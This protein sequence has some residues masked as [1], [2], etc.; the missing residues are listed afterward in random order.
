M[1][2]LSY[3]PFNT[4]SI[5]IA[6]SQCSKSPTRSKFLVSSLI[7]GSPSIHTFQVSKSGFI[8]STALRHIRTRLTL[9]YVKSI[10]CSLAC[11]QLDYANSILLQ[12][13]HSSH[14]DTRCHTSAG[15]YQHL[16]TLRQLHEHHVKWRIN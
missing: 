9:D 10:V 11:Y 3:I 7:A 13:S 8:T 14:I 5:N 6:S 12:T 15:P 16:Q 2:V 1:Y 4:Y